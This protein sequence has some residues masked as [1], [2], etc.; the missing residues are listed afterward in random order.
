MDEPRTTLAVPRPRA[1]YWVA[2]L[3]L[4][5][6][7]LY[8]SLRGID[9]LR[10]WHILRGAKPGAVALA[11]AVI[12]CSL[13]LRA[14]R[15]RVLLSAEESVPVPLAFWATSAGYLGNNLL[16]ARAGELVRTLMI[17]ART[18][19]SKTFVLTTALSER[20]A[21]A[22][23]L[24]TIS[25]TVLLTLAEKPGWIADAA[26]PFAALGFAGVAAIA[27]LPACESFWFRLLARMPLPHG[28]RDRLGDVL[29]HVLRGLR[30][31]HDA[32]RLG[33]FLGL[34]AVI[35]TLDGITT[36][37]GAH[38]IGVQLSLPLA[39]LLIAGLGL[40]SA[41]PSTPGYV[42]IY[43]F[44]AVSVLTP[45]GISRNDAIAYI[46]LFQAMIYV[47]ILVWGLLGLEREGF[48]SR[49]TVAASDLR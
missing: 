47:V 30:S 9:W 20:V 3:A 18:G 24:I 39:F 26:R 4:A 49:A 8:Y 48:G 29:R 13:F 7:L 35:L 43:Q 14:V 6:V 42:G 45:F 15:W 17:S 44:V 40:G 33:R 31:F 19:M 2:A 38:A 23:V 41:L 12:S 21:D 27:L 11:M 32:G 46:L 36:M 22:I 16:P 34:T 1:V 10:V 5:G 25:A 37:V 28:F